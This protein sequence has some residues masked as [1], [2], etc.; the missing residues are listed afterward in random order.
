MPIKV[1]IGGEDVE[2]PDVLNFATMKKIWAPLQIA[3]SKDATP[4]DRQSASI[5]ILAAALMRA[6][7][8]LSAEEIENRLLVRAG[9]DG[10]GL[11]EADLLIDAVNRL[12]A[13][14]GLIPKDVVEQ[15]QTGEAQPPGGEGE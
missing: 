11:S 5:R 6:N 2:V 15:P 12:L 14:S 1:K 13:S 9:D 8:E 10:R 7:P 4:I 3:S